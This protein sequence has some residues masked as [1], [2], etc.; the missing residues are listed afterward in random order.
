MKHDFY[1]I[2]ARLGNIALPFTM[3]NG[4]P[5]LRLLVQNGL[6]EP[7]RGMNTISTGMRQREIDTEL[8]RTNAW[9]FHQQS[10]YYDNTSAI[11]A[12]KKKD[13]DFVVNIVAKVP[14]GSEPSKRSLTCW[15]SQICKQMPPLTHKSRLKQTQICHIGD[16]M[17]SASMLL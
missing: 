16:K 3:K 6:D 13:W 9:F 15:W 5:L 4:Q 2:E 12:N 14:K 8:I 1:W 11:M 10:A 7:C 17:C